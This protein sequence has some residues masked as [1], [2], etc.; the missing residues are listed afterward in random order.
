MPL[1]AMRDK[2]DLAIRPPHLA[3][4]LLPYVQVN[5]VALLCQLLGQ[6]CALGQSSVVFY[7]HS[8]T[9]HNDAH[10]RDKPY[11]HLPLDSCASDRYEL[12]LYHE[13]RA[14]QAF[15]ARQLSN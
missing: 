15:V 1:R 6:Y 2:R 3:L 10:H 11:H 7:P 8:D 13:V 14:G 12:R 4:R 5:G 9:P